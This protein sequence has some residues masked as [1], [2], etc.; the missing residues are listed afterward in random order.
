MIVPLPNTSRCLLVALLLTLGHSSLTGCR[1]PEAPLS[2]PTTSTFELV[3]DP[4]STAPCRKPQTCVEDYLSLGDRISF[5]GTPQTKRDVES[6]LDAIKA[7]LIPSSEALLSPTDLQGLIRQATGVSP[8]LERLP[9]TQRTVRISRRWE[10]K[11]LRGYK[12]LIEDPYVGTWEATLLLPRGAGPFPAL[13]ASHGHADDAT[14]FLD[15]QHGRLYPKE[16]VAV[17]VHTQRVSFADEHEDRVARA[18]LAQ[19]GSLMAVRSYEVLVGLSLLRSFNQIDPARIALIGHS[20]GALANLL[21]VRLTGGFAAHVAD[22]I[23]EY[24]SW[25]DGLIADESLPM[26]YPHANQLSR[27]EGSP[28]PTIRL[29]YGYPLGPDS[30]LEFLSKAMPKS[31]PP[32]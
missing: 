25:D 28:I 32:R 21:T 22:G 7:G 5:D 29:E 23:A 17:L 4:G 31:A 9:S 30:V 13:V 27:T 20:G 19:G 8:L 10:T 2:L 18:L 26:L 16:G 1:A 24:N 15:G 6:Q 14:A 3:D 11:S 12:L